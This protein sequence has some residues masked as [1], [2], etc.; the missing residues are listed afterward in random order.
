MS[1]IEQDIARTFLEKGWDRIRVMKEL[2]KRFPESTV[3]VL[4]IAMT[5]AAQQISAKGQ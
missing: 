4:N 1:K 3:N 2:K 5:R